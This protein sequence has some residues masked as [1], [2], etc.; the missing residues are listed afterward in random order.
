MYF[1]LLFK[2][3]I[4]HST[5]VDMAD[6][7]GIVK[8][9]KFKL[10]IYSRQIKQ[11]NAIGSI[12]LISMT[13]GILEKDKTEQL[14][15]RGFVNVQDVNNNLALDEFVEILNRDSKTTCSGFQTNESIIALS[16]EFPNLINTAKYFDHMFGITAR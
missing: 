13:E 11:K 15:A 5:A 10:T 6:G 7:E 14:E 16:Q 4:L 3:M 9:S 1:M 12:H 8:S 2:L